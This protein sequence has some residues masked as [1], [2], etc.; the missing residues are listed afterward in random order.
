MFRCIMHPD[1]CCK[2]LAFDPGGRLLETRIN[3][4]IVRPLRLKALTGMKLHCWHY[5][6]LAFYRLCVGSGNL[7][8]SSHTL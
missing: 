4:I 6:L 5:A 2:S 7:A 1:P 3:D 8:L